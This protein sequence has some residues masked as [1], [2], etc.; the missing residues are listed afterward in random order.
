MHSKPLIISFGI[1][2]FTCLATHAQ[3]AGRTSHEFNRTPMGAVMHAL[4]GQNVSLYKADNNHFWQNPAALDSMWS[5]RLSYNMNAYFADIYNHGISYTL[6]KEKIG[7]M[8]LGVSYWNYGDM[9]ERDEFGNLLGN[10]SS[11]DFILNLSYSKSF[12]VFR[13]GSSLKFSHS[14]IGAFNSSA[15]LLDIG[16]LF[17]HPKQEFTVGMV[18]SNLGFQLDKFSDERFVMPFDVKL[19]TSYKPENMPMRLS[20]T[21]HRLYRYDIAYDDPA[22]FDGFDENGQPVRED[23]SEINKIT[24]HIILSTEILLAKGF[25]VQ[26]GYN[27]LKRSDL[28]L[29]ENGGAVGLSFGFLMKVKRIQFAYA[30]SIDH[31]SG[32]TNKISLM[33]DLNMFTKNKI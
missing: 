27:F 24:R 26:L 9:E 1:A 28:R 3:I 12:G 32:G 7:N 25:N 4:G 17:V 11:S 21:F 10:F 2:F 33:V 8:A 30:R 15:M 22:V 16:G 29:A 18:F 23:I 19:G 14:S 31:I 20:A 5:N 13:Y 6:S